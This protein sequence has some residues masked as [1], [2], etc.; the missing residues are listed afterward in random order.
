LS[1]AKEQGDDNPGESET[2][3]AHA[4]APDGKSGTRRTT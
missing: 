1:S 3:G 4:Q 2:Q